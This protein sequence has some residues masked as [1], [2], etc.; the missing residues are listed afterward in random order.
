MDAENTMRELTGDQERINALAILSYIDS[1]IDSDP[2]FSDRLGIFYPLILEAV[3]KQGASPF[4]TEDICDY[5][6]VEYGFTLP[7]HVADTL[8]SRCKKR[9]YVTGRRDN[10]RRTDRQ[11]DRSDL[12]RKNLEFD[13][14]YKETV[15]N[16][17]RFFELEGVEVTYEQAEKRLVS[18]LE[19]TFGSS[20]LESEVEGVRKLGNTRDKIL[21]KYLEHLAAEESNDYDIVRRLAQGMVVRQAVLYPGI[22]E[23]LPPLRGLV[24][25][26]DST[27]ICKLV[28][29]DTPQEQA[30]ATQAVG[31]LRHAGV[32]IRVFDATI[33]ELQGILG[34]VMDNW[35]KPVSGLGPKAYSLQMPKNGYTRSDVNLWRNDTEGRIRDLTGIRRDDIPQREKQYV[36]DE[37]K[38]EERLRDRDNRE[39]PGISARVRHD[40]NCIAGIITIRAGK[41][42]RESIAKAKALFVSDSPRTIANV[43]KWWRHDEGRD[44]IPP[45]FSLTALANYA[46]LRDPQGQETGEA[47]IDTS[48]LLAC[49]TALLPTD[50]MWNHFTERLRNHISNGSIQ[51]ETVAAV[52]LHTDLAANMSELEDQNW[53]GDE[54]CDETVRRAIDSLQ[55]PVRKEAAAELA[56]QEAAASERLEVTRRDYE[57]DA[58]AERRAHVAERERIEAERDKALRERDDERAK[59]ESK[60]ERRIDRFCSMAAVLVLMLIFSACAVALYVRRDAIGNRMS[61][62][63]SDGSFSHASMVDLALEVIGCLSFLGA[64]L[65]KVRGFIAKLMRPL[66]ERWH[67]KD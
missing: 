29:F 43:N 52:I 27:V 8:I 12:P 10:Y 30:Y 44:D 59:E 20:L 42:S 16:L 33:S 32:T 6:R 31:A 14:R 66:A 50:A 53:S 22:K 40:V 7:M 48:L 13:K 37:R 54:L 34:S 19:S 57:R 47:L 15:S 55:E 62:F 38:L 26:L 21:G 23:K 45:I 58:E 5:L 49:S 18:F 17:V 9:G 63:L 4:S 28:G 61:M 2:S 67:D 65:S 60:R 56:K 24:V 1:R 35:G 39:G 46:W 36:L 25:Y 11:I 41:I 64:C 51:K 3:A